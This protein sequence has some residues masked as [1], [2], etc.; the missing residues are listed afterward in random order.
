M[1]NYYYSLRNG[2]FAL[3]T[4][5]FMALTSPAQAVTLNVVGGQLLGASG[6]NVNGSLFDVEFLDGS[7]V[8]LFNGC[9][10]VT[11]FTFQTEIDARLAA[12][13]ILDTVLLDGPLGQFDTFPGLVA[14]IGASGASVGS[15]QIPFTFLNTT[16]AQI[17]SSFYVFLQ[18]QN[19]NINNFNGINGVF[20]DFRTSLT[21]SKAGV[22]FARFSQTPLS[23]V[24][25]PPAGLL[26]GSGLVFL[27][28]LSRRAKKLAHA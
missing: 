4:M 6:V 8:S 17:N 25:L 9:D 10:A 3:I 14:G 1:N 26:F 28:L 22:A 2:F 16:S 27:A 24:P 21:S 7:C 11:D 23:V 19:G 15:F 20:S 13:A 5:G 12:Q 18:F